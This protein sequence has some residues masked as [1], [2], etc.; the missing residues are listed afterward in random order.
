MS[1]LLTMVI[2]GE[3]TTA[4]STAWAVHELCDAP[5]WASEIRREADAVAGPLAVPPTLDAVNALAVAGAAA[6]EAMRL[7][8][9]APINGF[10]ANVDTR[11]GPYA[12]P[13]GTTI[14]LLARPQGMEP[15]YFADPTA[16]RPERWLDPTRR[17]A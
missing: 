16:F 3:D 12:V 14:M 1:N 5:Q 17:A 4:F 10:E 13:R 7:R 11:L 6:N 8:H 2:A 15:V 9:V